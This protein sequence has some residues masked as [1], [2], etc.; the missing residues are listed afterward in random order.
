MLT[1]PRGLAAPPTGNPGSA[2]VLFQSTLPFSKNS[3]KIEQQNNE[4]IG[5]SSI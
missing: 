1:P 5:G 4:A 2:P 3:I